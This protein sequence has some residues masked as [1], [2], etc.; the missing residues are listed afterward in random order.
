MQVTNIVTN[1]ASFEPE[2]ETYSKANAL[3]L[4]LAATAAYLST[5]TEASNGMQ[6]WTDKV[7]LEN[8]YPFS[9]RADI[10]PGG[11]I[12]GFVALAKDLLLLS[13]RGTDPKFGDWLTNFRCDLEPAESMP[14][15][16]HRGFHGAL[17][18]VW[19][20]IS[21][22]LYARGNRRVWITGHSQGGALA[23]ACAA[24]ATFG[25]PSVG[26]RGIYTYGQPRCGDETFATKCSEKLGSVMFRHVNK[27][28][29]V[30]GVP[31]I[32]LG[33]RHWGAKIFFD[34]ES[35]AS[36]CPATVEKADPVWPEVP[37]LV[38]T[39]HLMETAYLPELERN[40]KS[41]QS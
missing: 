7:G 39:S 21:P 13:F 16:V 28:D 36:V 4:G 31:P 14:G 24:R 37:D 33:Y 20:Q 32:S 15:R 9:A 30:P 11:M 27:H 23:V 1:L 6:A 8:C 5:E 26:I 29:I 40:V 22:H 19:S 34:P 18:A 3:F 41:K 38:V 12:E 2:A 25:Q 17:D 35:E 10:A